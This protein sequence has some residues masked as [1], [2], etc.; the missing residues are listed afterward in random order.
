MDSAAALHSARIPDKC[1][2]T[3]GGVPGR[4]RSDGR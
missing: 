1:N 2:D 3:L 4:A